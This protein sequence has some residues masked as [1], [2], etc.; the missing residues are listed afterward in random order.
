[1][2]IDEQHNA[3]PE[4]VKPLFWAQ[5]HI[6]WDQLY[7]G[8]ISSKWAQYVTTNSQYKLNGTVFYTQVISI[9]WAYMFDC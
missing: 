2:P 4:E 3:Y 9:V 1:M 6:G 8:C 5:Q 7:Y